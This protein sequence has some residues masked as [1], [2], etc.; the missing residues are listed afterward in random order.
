M[1]NKRM[2]EQHAPVRERKSLARN[3]FRAAQD[4]YQVLDTGTASSSVCDQ[5]TQKFPHE[6]ASSVTMSHIHCGP[7]RYARHANAA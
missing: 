3:S 6:C 2:S 4:V 7:E 5:A 1:R